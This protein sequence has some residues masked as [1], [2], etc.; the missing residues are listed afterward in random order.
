[1][2]QNTVIQL[3]TPGSAPED[4][5]TELLRNGARTLIQEAVRAEFDEFLA[6]FANERLEDGRQ[7][8][9]KNGHLPKREIQTGIG[10]VEVQVP[11]ARDRRLGGGCSHELLLRHVG[12]IEQGD[13]V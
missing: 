5:L 13:M 10:A 7:A 3:N 2:K 8:V 1:M 4:P 9:V 6:K 11:K 12:V